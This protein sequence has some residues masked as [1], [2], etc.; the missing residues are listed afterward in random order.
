MAFHLDFQETM[1]GQTQ[2]IHPRTHVPD[3]GENILL[4]GG[5]VCRFMDFN[6]PEFLVAN[7]MPSIF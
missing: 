4:V 2:E 6:C 3:S 7:Y 5:K 1:Q